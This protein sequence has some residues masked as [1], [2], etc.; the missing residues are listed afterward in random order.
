MTEWRGK[1][2]IDGGNEEGHRFLRRGDDSTV[3]GKK[4][5]GDAINPSIS[6]AY[7]VHKLVVYLQ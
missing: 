4:I 1:T 3:K 5:A 6:C 2:E 7:D